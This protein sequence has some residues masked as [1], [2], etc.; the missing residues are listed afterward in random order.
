MAKDTCVKK[1]TRSCDELGVCQAK[2][3]AG[4]KQFD[5][6]A[7]ADAAEAAYTKGYDSFIAGQALSSNPSLVADAM[8]WAWQEGW[9]DAQAEHGYPPEPRSSFVKR[10]AASAR[11]SAFFVAVL[12]LASAF[13]IA[14]GT[15][16]RG[17]K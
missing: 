2:G 3:C 16:V 11:L 4:C 5:A 15:T 7:A 10:G 6:M 13:V 17:A 1:Q 8:H 14:I 12:S 9:L